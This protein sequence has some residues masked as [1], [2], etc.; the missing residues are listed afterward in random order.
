[1]KKH[2]D[3]MHKAIS[4]YD[5][6]LEHPEI[7][8]HKHHHHHKKLRADK[9]DSDSQS[10]KNLPDADKVG[11]AQDDGHR[12]PVKKVEKDSE[13]EDEKEAN[14]DL[15]GDKTSKKEIAKSIREAKSLA[16]TSSSTPQDSK[17]APASSQKVDA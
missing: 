4:S 1:M 6:V 10:K 14:K 2:Y 12:K 9:F 13:S 8:K 17:Q 11:D 15:S 7:L 5:P 3:R 16:Q